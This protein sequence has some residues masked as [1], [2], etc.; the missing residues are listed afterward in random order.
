M[1]IGKIREIWRYPV[2]SMGG[3]KLNNC[4]VGS[5]GI[6][7]DRGWALRDESAGEIRGAKYLPKLMQ[8]SSR[9]R[10]QPTEGKI[11]HVDITL[12]DGTHTGSDEPNVNSRLSELLGRTVSLWPLQPADNKAHYRRAQTGSSIMGRIGRLRPLRPHVGKIIRLAGLEAHAREMFSR[13]PGEPLPDFSAIPPELF[14]FT[15]PPGTYFDLAPIHLLTTS[16]LAAMTRLNSSAAW[17]VRRFRP[18][19][20]V[21]TASGIEGLIE[22]EWGGR[23]V[24]LGELTLKCGMPTARCGM[25]T[26]AQAELPKD[27]T[28]LRTVVRHAGQNLGIY[29][30]VIHSGEVAVGDAV[31]LV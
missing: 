16:S 9:Y 22:A 21:E 3:E 6:H 25:T 7:G 23:T 13:E 29:A 1:L 17:D 24:R 14:E 31:E 28:V 20:L 5:N 2:K 27:P 10:E 19:F 15:S 12:P 30:S 26:H 11:P 8:C 18:N 4:S